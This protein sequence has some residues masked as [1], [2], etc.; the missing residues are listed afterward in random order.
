[1]GGEAVRGRA[2]FAVTAIMMALLLVAAACQR[3]GTGPGAGEEPQRG[4]NI[5]IGW[6]QEPAILNGFI[7]GGDL[8]ATSVV[9]SMM[10]RG[11]HRINPGLEFEPHMITRT[12]STD[13]G[14]LVVE[15]DKMSI[16][17]RL[18][19]GLQW[20]DGQPITSE[21]YE[22]TW[23]TIMNPDNSILSREGYDQIES[24]DASDPQ[25]F[26]A[27]FKA[28]YN[29]WILLFNAILPKHDLEGKDF[30][31]EMLEEVRVSSGP[32]IFGEW[33][34]GD[35]ITLNRN[36]NFWGEHTSYLDSVTFRY[37]TDTAALKNA[38]RAGE[39]EFIQPPPDIAQ[40]EE[41]QAFPGVTVK[42]ESGTVWEHLAFQH[43]NGLE[44][45]EVR[46]A[47]AYGIDRNALTEQR[48]K[49][50]VAPLQSFVVPELAK[51]TSDPWAKYTRDVEKAKQLMQQAGY[52]PEKPL[53][54]TI[55]TTSGNTAREDNEAY[56]Q[57]Q[58]AE[59]GIELTI[60]NHPATT[61]FGEVTPQGTFQIGE[62]AWL[63]SPG[64]AGAASLVDLFA[65]DQIPT[66]ANDFEG[67]NYYRYNNPEILTIKNQL[68]TT[69]DEDEGAE[70]IKK[71]AQIMAD[72]VAILPLYQRIDP[73]A[74]I[75]SIRGPENNPSQE[76]PFWNIED[77]WKPQAT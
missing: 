77:W 34:K 1:M 52:S 67:Q 26:T 40:V 58:L 15:G 66:E 45:K 8:F 49:G 17:W 9:T 62:W 20:S 6:D 54:L 16:T 65:P 57:Q 73:I 44:K 74:Y 46:E 56:F 64:Y 18:R 3:D 71:V 13:N 61:F 28:L 63:G 29:Q 25:A 75:E 27:N 41:I 21:D 70:L 11:S 14:D 5:V 43:Q 32:F 22:F 47:I 37:I 72:D 30:D 60:E 55:S 23:Q 48:L 24:V 7:T 38:F 53:K 69:L 50:Q 33:A 51:F 36:D 68:K 2:K 35:S 59:I 19:D 10:L 39:V 12:P 76:G 42:I 4:G 31:Q